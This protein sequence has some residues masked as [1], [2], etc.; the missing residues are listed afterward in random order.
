MKKVAREAAVSQGILHYYFASKRAILIAALDVVMG[1]LDRRVAALSEGARD[2]RGRLRAV[3]RGCLGLAEDSR[4]FWVVFVEFWG[5]M[6]HDQEMSRINAALY[7]RLRRTLGAT[8]A[9]GTR[10]GVFRRV[11]PVEAGRGHPGPRRRA[12]AP[13]HVRCAR[14]HP[15]AR[16]A[17]LR[18]RGEPVPREGVIISRGGTRPWTWR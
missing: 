9:L 6:M 3:I 11:D 5:E 18:G 14:A 7:E 13:A 16:G 8:V 10:E 4:E 1:D 12:L 17:G 15:R 2:A